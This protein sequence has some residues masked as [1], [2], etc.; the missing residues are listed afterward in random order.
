MNFDLFGGLNNGI[1]VLGCSAPMQNPKVNP[2]L[3]VFAEV[4]YG[5]IDKSPAI[6][7]WEKLAKNF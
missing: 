6:H 7:R 2:I 5:T 3:C 4:P 1:G